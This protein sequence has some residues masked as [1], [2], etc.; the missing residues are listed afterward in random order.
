MLYSNKPVYLGD[1]DVDRRPNNDNDD[2]KRTDPKL[3]YRIKELKD[4]LFQKHVYRIPLGLI[5]NLGLVNFTIK[6]D[7]KILITLEREMNK[8]FQTNKK[9]AA[10]PALPDALI[11]FYDH[12][13][14]T[15]N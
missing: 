12:I 15:K 2:D 4:D 7:T 11:N 14:L 13:F 1:K 8:L 5:V 10:I 3:T 6:T 9:L